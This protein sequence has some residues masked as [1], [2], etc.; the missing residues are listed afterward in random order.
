M[1]STIQSQ[2]RALRKSMS[3][4]L[5]SL[6]PLSVMEQSRA[7]AAQVLALPAFQGCKNVSCFLSMPLGELDTSEIV[8]E[9]LK[10][11][12][13]SLFVPKVCSDGA[14]EFMKLYNQ[15][16]LDTLSSGLWGI[17]EPSVDWENSPRVNAMDAG[18]DVI[19]MPGVA[20][21]RS[22]SRLGHGKGYYDRYIARYVASGRPRP[23][24]VS[25]ALRNQLLDLTIPVDEHD[26]K[27]DMI[28]TPDEIVMV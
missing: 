27:M 18:L 12:N 8:A 11:E 17:R 10:S 16:D 13:K 23:L 21:D 19:L 28:V 9:I 4:A 14:M 5:R 25:L 7:V 24:L 20:F 15:R 26:C 3:T 1:L 22:M 2:K 6:D